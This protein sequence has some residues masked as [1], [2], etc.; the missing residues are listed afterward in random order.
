MSFSSTAS[1]PSPSPSTSPFS[2]SPPLPDAPAPGQEGS[3]FG[4]DNPST[5][6]LSDISV[7]SIFTDIWA[8]GLQFLSTA[9][10]DGVS[11]PFTTMQGGWNVAPSTMDPY[12]GNTSAT[13]DVDAFLG[14]VL[15]AFT[16]ASPVDANP[17]YFTGG[18]DIDAFAPFQST[19]F[20]NASFQN[21][22]FQ[23]PVFG[24][25]SAAAA[26]GD[27]S[28]TSASDSS[29]S[30]SPQASNSPSGRRFVPDSVLTGQTPLDS[31]TR[32]DGK[33]YG[34]YQITL[35][36]VKYDAYQNDVALHGRGVELI[37]APV[38]QT[39]SAPPPSRE[40]ALPASP[41][42]AQGQSSTQPSK[43]SDQKTLAPSEPLIGPRP[44]GSDPRQFDDSWARS[45]PEVRQTTA[46]E[47]TNTKMG[48]ILTYDLPP[49]ETGFQG[50]DYFGYAFVYGL[51]QG[52]YNPIKSQILDERPTYLD[53]NQNVQKVPWRPDRRDAA[54]AWAQL[55]IIPLTSPGV[56]GIT[57]T[58]GVLP[59]DLAGGGV[60]TR[61]PINPFAD[62]TGAEIDT[63]LDPTSIKAGDY[64]QVP[65]SATESGYPVEDLARV[66]RWGRR[67]L[68]P[69]DWVV[70]GSPGD[71]GGYVRSFK[72]DPSR[73]V[74][75]DTFLGE[76]TNQ[77]AP[78]VTGQGFLVPPNSV[79][80]P[81]GWGPDGW[82]KGLFG[83]RKYTP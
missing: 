17:N 14:K 48:R 44:A 22:T 63:A 26:G 18:K 78:R 21:I 49:D 31:V 68:E 37:P 32:D 61:L 16:N 24:D 12:T 20:E 39:T 65:Y 6:A 53:S 34:H 29:Q 15:D 55:L 45:H 79:T 67:G 11:D 76:P 82:I 2:N 13:G 50:E 38:N 5:E 57:K 70:P 58:P 56:L 62:L 66:S 19:S 81:T 25:L 10:Q 71:F 60:P 33:V 83:Q 41:P 27:I 69:G 30:D 35:D 3:E 42:G 73:S 59:P 77:V 43:P 46:A 72:W 64:F 47:T 51:K 28:K 52:I 9:V 40:S 1:G 4:P 74:L 7:D 80:W 75:G 23:N 8:G 54:V 36:G